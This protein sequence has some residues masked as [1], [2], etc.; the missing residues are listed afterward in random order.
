MIVV[1]YNIVIVFIGG[2]CFSRYKVTDWGEF[3]IFI[4]EGGNFG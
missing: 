3:F 4:G 1:V 2:L